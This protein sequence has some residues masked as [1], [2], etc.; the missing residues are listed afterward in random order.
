MQNL[1]STLERKTKRHHP[2]LSDK[3]IT[4]QSYKKSCDINNIMKMASKTGRLPE[5]TKIPQ[6][7][8]FSETPT[9]ETAFEVAHAAANAFMQ[10]PAE[11]RKLIDNDPSKLENFVSNP[12]NKDLCIKYGLMD[13]PEPKKTPVVDESQKTVQTKVEAS[14]ETTKE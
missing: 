1:K 11:V 4:D 13:K 6:Y 12:E 2:K 14:T 7:G 3:K 5:N 9:L 10:L 8:D